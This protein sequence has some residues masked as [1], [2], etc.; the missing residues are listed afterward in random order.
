MKKT[1][2]LGHFEEAVLTAVMSLRGSDAY[3]FQ[4]YEKVREL[5]GD[6]VNLGA[7]YVTLD[8]L[9]NKGYISSIPAKEPSARGGT[10]TYIYRL[11]PSGLAVL[12]NSIEKR[13][14]VSKAFLAAW[15]LLCKAKPNI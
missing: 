15:R 10:L 1:E 14:R 9:K 5:T 6:D 12:K 11:E 3:G 13:Q 2:S 4:I 8:R 7:I